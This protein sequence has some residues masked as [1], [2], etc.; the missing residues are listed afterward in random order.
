[1]ETP[2][3]DAVAV[4]AGPVRGT[5]SFVQVMS[6]CW[7]Q[8]S[9]TL[10]EILWRWAYGIPVLLILWYQGARIL[11]AVPLD[12]HALESMSL[13]DPM[14]AARTLD[15]AMAL[16]LPPVLEVARWLAP[17][18][19]MVWI[20]VSSLGRTAVLRR[21]DPRLHARPGTLMALQT[22]RVIALLVSFAVW[23]MGMQWAA[24]VTVAAPIARGSEPNLVGYFALVIV[25]TLGIFSLWAIASWGLSMAPLM[26][27]L[28][29]LGVGGSFR[30]A[31]GLGSL[32]SKLMEINL[33]MGIVK[34]ILIALA[35]VFSSTPLPFQA[36][37]TPAFL[38]W[39]WAAV[40]VMYFIA[41]DFFHVA[42]L[43]AYLE[44][45]RA[46]EKPSQ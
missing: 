21:V 37:A 1:M 16:L 30:A 44:L 22:V 31:F 20:V 5:Q 25:G 24:R 9:W 18:L 13:L 46:C 27:M 23:F 12:T 34:I 42:R 10:L 15:G 28:R 33:V 39:W 11:K 4:P 17:L 3:Q 6:K 41:S 43:V 29:N 45:W 26:A 8:P 7:G 32:R 36:V 19:V 38:A 35:T 14:G 2:P 40:S